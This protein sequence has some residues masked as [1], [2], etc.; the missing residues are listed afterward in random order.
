[1]G[2]VPIYGSSVS[3]NLLFFHEGVRI[4]F[5]DEAELE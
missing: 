1:M 4:D 5:M 2:K 3:V